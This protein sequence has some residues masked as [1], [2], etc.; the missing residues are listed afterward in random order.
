M[1]LVINNVVEC[2]ISNCKRKYC[3]SIEIYDNVISE[4]EIEFNLYF[5]LYTL[6]RSVSVSN[7]E[8]IPF[9][10]DTTSMGVIRLQISVNVTTSENNIETLSNICR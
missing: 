2:G 7:I 8:Y 3:Q 10:I 5:T 4:S 1:T 9:N 6:L